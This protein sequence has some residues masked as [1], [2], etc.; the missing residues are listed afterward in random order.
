MIGGPW[1]YVGALVAIV[2]GIGAGTTYVH[3]R[4]FVSGQA[5]R[6]A[7]YAP[8][9]Q[10]ARDAKDAADARANALEDAALKINSASEKDHALLAKALADRVADADTRIAAVLRER[11]AGC[12]AAGRESVP[13]ISG[14]PAVADGGA[15]GQQGDERLA[16]RI[17]AVGQQCEHDAAAVAGFQLWYQRQAARAAEIGR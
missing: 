9:L 2:V 3:H 4:G 11:A 13:R 16:G 5:E 10:A 7:H 6:E 17:S 8:L 1:I 15:A 14:S 12:A